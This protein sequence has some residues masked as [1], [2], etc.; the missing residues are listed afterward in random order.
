M[1]YRLR[2]PLFM[3]VV[4]TLSTVALAQR[5]AQQ[6]S[7]VPN[8]PA[9]RTPGGKPDLSGTWTWPGTAGGSTVMPPIQ[10]T[11]W[12]LDKFNWNNG[13]ESANAPGVYA[14]R[15]TRVE[16][17]PAYHCYP[18][19]L[20]RLGPPPDPFRILSQTPIVTSNWIEIIQT[21]TMVI[22][23]YSYRHEIRYIYLD[24][25]DHPE[26]IELTWNGHSIGR[27]E[28]DTLVVDTIGLRDESW[29]DNV[30]HEHSDQLHIV[31]RYRRLDFGRLDLDRTLT[32]P[33]ALEKPFTTHA[34]ARL[35]PDRDY[36]EYSTYD[37]QQFMVRKPAFGE[38][39]NGLLGI[40][41]HP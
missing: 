21:P 2:G 33:V 16:L 4:L 37:C 1:K 11:K 28:G 18:P 35:T 20:A 9:P 5:N 22:M 31:E 41:D 13:P 38:G 14:G 6:R 32:D 17:D 40:N 24:G 36:N 15:V 3:V 25:R 26:N 12:G 34:V 8:K 7:E 19:G 29:L 10:L 27:W 30:G 39:E 23:L